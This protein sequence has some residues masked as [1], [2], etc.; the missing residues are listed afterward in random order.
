MDF[1]ASNLKSGKVYLNTNSV[2][3]INF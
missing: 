1:I 2:Y 3:F